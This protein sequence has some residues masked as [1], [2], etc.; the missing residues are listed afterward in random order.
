[1]YQKLVMSVLFD[2][3]DEGCNPG[4]AMIKLS[5]FVNFSYVLCEKPFSREKVKKK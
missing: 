1:M 5:G 4:D 2:F 3:M